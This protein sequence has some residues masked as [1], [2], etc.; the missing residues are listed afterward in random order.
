MSEISSTRKPNVLHALEWILVFIGAATCLVVVLLF[1]GQ[2]PDELWPFPGLYFLDITI[3][4]LFGAG[5]RII[6][7]SQTNP[8]LL[9]APWITGGELLPMVIL[10]A[11]SIGVFIL[12]AML[13]F[14]LSGI[15]SDMQIKKG[16]AVHLRI[17][18]IAAL[19]QIALMIVVNIF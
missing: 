11:F 2:Q 3:L 9:A 19:I 8:I 17:A 6:P 18:A 7:S 4:A 1:A 12:P 15:L 10:G 16:Y 5:S 14:I 13:A